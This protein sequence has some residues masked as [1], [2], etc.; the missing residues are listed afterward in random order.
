MGQVLPLVRLSV[1]VTCFGLVLSLSVPFIMHASKVGMLMKKKGT[2]KLQCTTDVAKQS[3][4][5]TCW[6]QSDFSHCNQHNQS[7]CANELHKR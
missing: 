1:D 4:T 2:I 5:W 7:L 6:V 3:I